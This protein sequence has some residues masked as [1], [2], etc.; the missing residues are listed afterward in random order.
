MLIN[1]WSVLLLLLKLASYI[2]I[3]SLAGT[4]LVRVSYANNKVT[5][6]Y[7]G[8][9]FDYLK[10]WQI[11]CVALGCFASMLQ[12]PIEAGAMAESGL[13]G[14]LDPFMLEIVWQSV[15][16]EQAALRI[17]A[18]IFA[19]IAV[20]TW[21]TST[22]SNGIINFACTL[23]MLGF[24]TYSFTFSG[25]SANQS[26]W[27]KIIFTFHLITIA[28]W[29]GALWPLYKSCTLLPI[30]AIKSL[31]Q[32]F[33]QLAIVIV[34]VLLISGITLLFEYLHSF[35]ELFTSNYGQLILLKLLLVS[36]MLLL[37]AW[38][39][40]FLVPQMTQQQHIDTLKR[41]ISVEMCIA[42]FV[43]ITT[44]VLTTL[45]GPPI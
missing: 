23:L 2:A 13:A 7:L 40:L 41:S 29:V 26:S 35:A 32:R 3:A 19:L 22:H 33:G 37:G 45:V 27:L 39:K 17:P 31:M 9:F 30:S 38:H 18:F 44:S 28:S 14:M 11:I 16:G 21:Q 10:R 15:I 25:H 43:L 20:F 6:Q 5:E 24:V 8:S 12:I 34:A 36:A 4:L 1:E 42:F